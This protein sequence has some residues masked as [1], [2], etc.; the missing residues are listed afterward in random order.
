MIV[1]LIYEQACLPQAGIN[2][3][4][5]TKY[6]IQKSKILSCVRQACSELFFL[7][8]RLPPLVLSAT[9]QK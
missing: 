4:R 8:F 3:L 5:F 1:N 7:N 6:L 2:N 9:L